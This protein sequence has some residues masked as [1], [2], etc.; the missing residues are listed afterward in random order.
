MVGA[1]TRH[2]RELQLPVSHPTVPPTVDDLAVASGRVPGLFNLERSE[3]YMGTRS[4]HHPMGRLD[5]HRGGTAPGG[6]HD[7]DDEVRPL[8]QVSPD[9]NVQTQTLNV[10]L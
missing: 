8:T 5:V 10:H 2:E 1:G 4:L 7:D 6:A 3:D 9:R